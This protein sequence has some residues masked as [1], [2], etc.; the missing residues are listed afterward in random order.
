MPVSQEDS[1]EGLVPVLRTVVTRGRFPSFMFRV[2][3]VLVGTVF[4]QACWDLT[5][6]ISQRWWST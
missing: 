2:D 5:P 6:A 3:M 4:T 1:T